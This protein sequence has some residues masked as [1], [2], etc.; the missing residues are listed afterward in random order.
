[1]RPLAR[2]AERLLYEDTAVPGVRTRSWCLM[3]GAY[4]PEEVNGDSVRTWCLEHNR[5]TAHGS[6]RL[7]ETRYLVVEKREAP[8]GCRCGGMEGARQD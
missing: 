6:Y 8:G 1:M 7:A 2:D 3:C 4:S 5:V